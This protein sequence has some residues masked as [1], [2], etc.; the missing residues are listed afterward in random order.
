MNGEPVLTT[1][2]ELLSSSRTRSGQRSISSCP[3]NGVKWT[4]MCKLLD[5]DNRREKPIQE[6]FLDDTDSRSLE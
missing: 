3:A 5:F 6:F 2:R 4:D 1:I